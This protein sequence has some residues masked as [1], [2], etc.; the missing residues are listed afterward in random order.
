TTP[1]SSLRGAIPPAPPAY[2]H[3]NLTP[4]T[5]PTPNHTTQATWQSHPVRHLR[6]E[7]LT[8]GDVHAPPCGDDHAP[9]HATVGA[10][11]GATPSASFAS[12]Y[13]APSPRACRRCP[14]MP[15]R[16]RSVRVSSSRPPPRKIPN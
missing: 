11:S 12:A 9:P 3:H 1:S 7:V 4:P 10:A 16:P 14:S 13:T 6:H 2:H 8:D 5:S 15:G